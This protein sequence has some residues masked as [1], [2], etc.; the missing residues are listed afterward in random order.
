VQQEEALSASLL[1]PYSRGNKGRNPSVR[2]WVH[3]R[4]RMDIKKNR[5]IL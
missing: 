2:E 5:N 1:L 3:P 4:A